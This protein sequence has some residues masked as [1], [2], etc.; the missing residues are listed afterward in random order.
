[1]LDN[2]WVLIL[3]SRNAHQLQLA[4][5]DQHVQIIGNCTSMDGV[6]HIFS[7]INANDLLPTTHVHCVGNIRLAPMHRMT[8]TDFLDCMH[9]N[10][11]SVFHMLY[12]FINYLKQS[13]LLGSAMLVS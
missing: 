4:Y 7:Q 1:M 13:S 5:G 3:V 10:L 9:T 8:E 2:D 6:K 12:G 11:F